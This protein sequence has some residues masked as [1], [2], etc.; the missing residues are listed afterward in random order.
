MTSINCTYNL[1]GFIFCIDL[2]FYFIAIFLLV[3][4]A[5][6]ET[7][8]LLLNPKTHMYMYIQCPMNFV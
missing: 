7:T 3:V 2:I 5:L 1:K 4:F 8:Y 6:C